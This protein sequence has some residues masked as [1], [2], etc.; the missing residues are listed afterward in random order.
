M[1]KPH[2]GDCSNLTCNRKG[3]P[4]P[5]KSGFCDKCNYEQKQEK[6][7]LAGKSTK[8][9]TYV[10]EATGEGKMFENIIENLGD[11]ATCCFVCKKPIAV[12]M[13]GNMAHVLP[14]GKY[15]AYRLYSKN[16][17][18]LCYNLS[19]DN[20]HHK[21]DHTP[22]STLIGEGWERLF[23]LR[24]ELKEQYPEII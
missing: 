11:E 10:R 23:K 18:L 16:V 17:V 24:D 8:K 12:L 7:K 9:Y 21:Y 5:V 15:E 19:G 13:Y 22:H 20:C 6:K 3:V 1:F 4:I 2:I 14:K